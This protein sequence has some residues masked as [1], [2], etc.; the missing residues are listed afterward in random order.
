[1]V[2]EIANNANMILTFLK[3]FMQHRLW[4]CRGWTP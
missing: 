3:R 1:M 2:D 4:S